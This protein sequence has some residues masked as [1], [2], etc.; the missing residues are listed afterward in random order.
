M[1]GLSA[2]TYGKLNRATNKSNQRKTLHEGATHNLEDVFGGHQIP[3][4]EFGEA[5]AAEENASASRGLED[6]A[7]Q[8]AVD[9]GLLGLCRTAATIMS[10][11]I[12]L[13]RTDV[14][15]RMLL[16]RVRSRTPKFRG[17]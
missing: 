2:I 4:K 11:I 13:N 5:R 14:H 15:T 10:I 1:R 9:E 12:I 16:S 7:A 3:G 6:E 17:T 8:H